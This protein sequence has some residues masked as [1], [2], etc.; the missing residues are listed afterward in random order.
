METRLKILICRRC[1]RNA[2]PMP[3]GAT[4]ETRFVCRTCCGQIV[5]K[6]VP[7]ADDVSVDNTKDQTLVRFDRLARGVSNEQ[8]A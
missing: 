3:P 4:S 8:A 6:K 1:G 5:A 7:A 2:I